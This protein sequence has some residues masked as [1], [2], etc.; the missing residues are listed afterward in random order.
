MI[1]LFRTERNRISTIKWEKRKVWR[2]KNIESN[3]CDYRARWSSTRRWWVIVDWIKPWMDRKYLP[4]YYDNYH[5]FFQGKKEE[6]KTHNYLETSIEKDRIFS[7]AVP[8]VCLSVYLLITR[9]GSRSSDSRFKQ[10]RW[11]W[12]YQMIKMMVL[13]LENWI[14]IRI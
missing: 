1:F 14:K 4:L 12:Y 8:I 13:K 5:I 3:Y 9:I 11:F 6:E 10:H 7:S 2:A